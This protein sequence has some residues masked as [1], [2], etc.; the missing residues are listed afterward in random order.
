MGIVSRQ[1]VLKAL[2]MIQRQPQVGETIEDIITNGVQAASERKGDKETY[3]FAVT[4]Q[5]TTGIGTISYGVFTTLMTEA[6]NRALKPY[7]KGD[8][9]IE[10]M[11][12]YFIKPVQMES[13]L[14][15][16]PKVLDVGRKFGKVDVEVYH[17]GVLVGKSLMICQLIDRH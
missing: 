3:Q 8:I 13:M 2:Q 9:V 17:D 11:T 4:P 15:I 16:H 5:M 12:I 7:K 6:A 10:N 1:D 14:D